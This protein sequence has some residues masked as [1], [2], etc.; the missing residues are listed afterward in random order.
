M[1][2]NSAETG[3]AQITTLINN[4]GGRIQ[5]SK[6]KNLLSIGLSGKKLFEF[7][8]L[9]TEKRNFAY[10]AAIFFPLIFFFFFRFCCRGDIGVFYFIGTGEARQ[11]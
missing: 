9:A 4:Y 1:L 10:S 3:D 6:K 2:G 8:N 7:E 11:P 5:D